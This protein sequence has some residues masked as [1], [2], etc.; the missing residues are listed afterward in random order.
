MAIFDLNGLKEV[1]DTIGHLAGD[2][3]IMNFANILRTSI[4]Q[5]HFVGRYGGD[6]FVILTLGRS[7]EYLEERA[8]ML[9]DK[10]RERQIPNVD[11]KQTDIVTITVGA[12]C[13][14]PHKPNKMWDFLTAADET[15]YEQKKEKR[16]CVRFYV[17]KDDGL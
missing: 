10:V 9:V 13:A 5:Q 4:P 8:K 6:E 12:V 7:K 3:L 17:G 16:G 1:N 15:L 14:V 2:T 11:S